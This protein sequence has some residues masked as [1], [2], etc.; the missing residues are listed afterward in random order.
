MVFRVDFKEVVENNEEHGSAS[1]EDSQRVQLGVCNHLEGRS[2]LVRGQGVSVAC[3]G[4]IREPNRF[5][6]FLQIIPRLCVLL[7]YCLEAK[8]GMSELYC[9]SMVAALVKATLSSSKSVVAD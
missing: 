1:E 6:T 4:A 9:R 2:A 7:V 5:R 8:A 3:C